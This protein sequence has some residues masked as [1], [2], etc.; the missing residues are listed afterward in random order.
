MIA[1]LLAAAA[2]ASPQTLPE[3]QQRLQEERAAAQKLAGREATLLGRLADLERQ[4]EV[5]GRAMRAAQA[6]LRAAAQRLAQVEER[7]QQAQAQVDGATAV[8]GPRLS[9]RYRM[10][11]E[12]Y[13]RFLLGSRSIAEVLRR[14]RIFNAILES[15]LD[16]LAV[17][18]F[19]A[20]GAKAARDE[21]AAARAEQEQS[22][23]AVSDRRQSLEERVGQQRTLL[24]SVQREKGLHE[25]AARELEEAER[26]LQ[27]RLADIVQQPPQAPP[28]MVAPEIQLRASIRKARG[29][30]GF[31]L[32]TGKIEVHFGRTTDK[33]FGTITLQRGIDIRAPL[34]TPV[35][36]V[37]NGKV[38]H[39]GWFKGYGNLLIIDHGQ[40][41]FS[42]MA[43]LDQLEKAVGEIV[44]AGDEVGTVG[45]TG[46]LK[47]AYLYFELRDRQK[48]LDPERWLSRTRKP[49][50]LLAGAKGG[51]AR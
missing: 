31:P 33:R 1:L 47:G 6:R 2:A 41:I 4:I 46:S 20:D 27:K 24:A 16:A 37:W 43:H 26:E 25:Q 50:A 51:A 36:A 23:Q 38:A 17:L 8:V 45:D 32:E 11:R 5:E 30:L 40:N 21:L 29:K 39:A 42:L 22:L 13:L 12:G 7:A 9:A 3:V 15:D 48:P 10:G 49:P 19:D 28:A 14:R 18:R 35:R 34:G 44:H